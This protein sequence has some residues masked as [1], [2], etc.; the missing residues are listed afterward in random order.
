MYLPEVIILS[1]Q[2]SGT[3]LLESFLAKHPL[4]HAKGEMFLKFIRSNV[5]VEN[6]PGKINIGILMYGQLRTFLQLGGFEYNP[7]IIHLLRN[8]YN[9]ALSRLQMGADRVQM[10]EAYQAHFHIE[11]LSRPEIK[12]MLD[13]R[14]RPD[15][16][17]VETLASKITEEQQVFIQMLEN[18]PHLQLNYEEIVRDNESVR[19][20]DKEIQSRIL[21]YL[22]VPD[23][24]EL[25]TT[26]YKTGITNQ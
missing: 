17:E 8:P 24:C 9:V 4:F 20:L 5:L 16:T 18:T 19:I 12:K 23:D 26:Y 14:I 25:Y 11:D 3:H 13:E 21:S 1:T 22:D 15:L 7:K 2:R 6:A 10:G